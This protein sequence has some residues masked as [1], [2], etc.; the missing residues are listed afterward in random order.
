MNRK[1]FI[2]RI[3]I[4]L[5]VISY[6]QVRNKHTL[7]RISDPSINWDSTITIT[8]KQFDRITLKCTNLF[9]G[10]DVNKFT[11]SEH[12][13]ILRLL[14]SGLMM[15]LKDTSLFQT[16]EYSQFLKLVHSTKYINKLLKLYPDNLISRGMG[17]YFPKL[18]VEYYGTPHLRSFFYVEN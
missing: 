18:K 14:N 17:Y 2:L 3:L 16:N 13:L 1:F 7:A 9:Y 8:K 12:T 6:G 5:S 15:P 10:T 11:G 4:L